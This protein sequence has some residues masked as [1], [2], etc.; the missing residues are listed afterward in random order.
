MQGCEEDWGL[1]EEE[2]AEFRLETLGVV[3]RERVLRVRAGGM[4]VD[5]EQEATDCS[6]S[7]LDV[8]EERVEGLGE[9]G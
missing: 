7:L 8:D 3:R 4:W 5:E 2:E 9:R 1:R 6:S